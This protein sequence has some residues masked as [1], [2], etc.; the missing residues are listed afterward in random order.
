MR[1]R[2]AIT[3]SA[4]A[5]LVVV[6]VT[7][8]AS[9]GD[10]RPAADAKVLEVERGS[11]DAPALYEAARACEDTLLDP[12][13]ALA[14]YDR[15]LREDPDASVAVAAEQHAARLRA[16]LAGGHA[17]EAKE[18]ARLVAEADQLSPDEV[19][20]RGDALATTAWSGGPEAA[21]WVAEW[22]RR[23]GRFA[24][25]DERYAR[26]VEK[27]PGST[28]AQRAAAG[29]AG[30]AIDARAWDRA[31]ALIDALPAATPEDVAVRD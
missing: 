31:R 8:R 25:A 7:A 4:L 15:L 18:L 5:L 19:V 27:W 14:L 22:L 2:A 24:A 11:A 10:D 23:A 16:Q 20:M 28:E 21:L 9:A 12:P 29:R 1:A 6:A 13:R 3:S 30:A 26:V 17:R